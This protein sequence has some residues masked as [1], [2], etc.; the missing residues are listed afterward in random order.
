MQME[1]EKTVAAV[2]SYGFGDSRDTLA[3]VEAL[4][5]ASHAD[6]AAR[7]RIELALVRLLEDEATLAAKQFA[8]KKL[9]AIGTDASI[10]ALEKLLADPDQ[11][12]VEAA[13]YALARQPS[14]KVGQALRN[15]LSNARGN[16]L[17]AIINLLGERQDAASAARIAELTANA[18]PLVY[19]SAICAL[20]KIASPEAVAAL[21]KLRKTADAKKSELA[22][23]ALLQSAQQLSKRGDKKNAARIYSSLNHPD[24]PTHIRRGASIAQRR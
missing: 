1:I 6:L 21:E 23:H 20:G 4:I 10:P 7:R 2:K 9:W 15:A 8:S 18:E 3:A 22:A 12:M 17:L 19:D 11:V 5:N 14:P 24:T 13:C 16:G